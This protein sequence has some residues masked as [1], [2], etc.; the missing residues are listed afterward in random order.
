MPP[1]PLMVG[2]LAPDFSFPCTIRPADGARTAGLADY[3]GR[4]L[5]LVFYPRDFSLACPTELTALSARIGE[6]QKRGCEL[7]AV[8]TDT[9]ATHEEWIAAPRAQGGLGGLAFPLG[10]DLE[11]AACKAYGVFLEW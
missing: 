10:S 6:F 9:V 11:G 4:W 7:L 5:M 1:A 3:R 2:G 8:S